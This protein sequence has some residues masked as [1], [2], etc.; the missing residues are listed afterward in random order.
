MRG[1]TK[2]GGAL[3][4]LML[5]LGGVTGCKDAGSKLRV[6]VKN[7]T[8]QRIIGEMVRARLQARRLP[9]DRLTECDATAR[10]QQGMA[11]G[12]ID[13]L[14]EYTGTAAAFTAQP[15][16]DDFARVAEVMAKRGQSWVAPLGFDN[17]YRVLVTPDRAKTIKDLADLSRVKPLRVIAPAEFLQRPRD[18]LGAL[19]TR[20]GLTLAARPLLI[21]SPVERFAA[22]RDGR[23]DVAIGYGTDGAID[24]FQLVALTDSAGF[25]PR[26]DA[27]IVVRSARLTPRIAAALKPLKGRINTSAMRRLNAAVELEGVRPATAAR[28]FLLREDL[29]KPDGAVD[30]AAPPLVIA[31]NATIG[32]R[33]RDIARDAFPSRAVRVVNLDPRTAVP[34]RARLAVLPA[35]VLAETT[36]V[37]A[38]AVIGRGWLHAVRKGPGGVEGRIGVEPTVGKA[39]RARASRVATA[40]EL[41]EAV[42]AGQLDVA[43][44]RAPLKDRGVTD[45]LRSGLILVPTPTG[46]PLHQR[47]RIPA[48]TY[49][50][51]TSAIETWSTQVLLAS[52]TRQ[53]LAQASGPAGAVG[54][55]GSAPLTAAQQAAI[56]RAA[57]VPEAPDP[58]LPQASVVEV[59]QHGG[60]L[61]ALLNLLVVL[62]MI[63]WIKAVLAPVVVRER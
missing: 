16:A 10:C 42:R 56:V 11:A 46:A 15:G 44:V 58:A 24:D 32:R 52:P 51:Q 13:I 48:G 61:D 49:P 45:A 18:G 35:D 47:A 4:G 50:N 9:V 37:L 5:C 40:P 59:A 2:T 57:G 27:A 14:I 62:F 21:E 63:G 26:Y 41:F 23:G 1:L 34:G 25:F 6:G 22:L 53:R 30:K 36:G 7:F 12:E 3:I 28:R 55:G 8:E 31:A 33:V 29:L 19:A 60:W 54:Q 43:L 39:L 20:Y 38:T 17:G